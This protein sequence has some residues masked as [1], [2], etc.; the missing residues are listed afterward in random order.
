L[1]SWCGPCLRELPQLQNIY[2]HL[3]D[4]GVVVLGIDDEKKAKAESFL[5]KHHYTFTMLHDA[6]KL[7]FKKY[8]ASVIPLTVIINRKGVISSVL[9]GYHSRKKL[10]EAIKSAGL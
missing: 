3:K 9:A 2:Q 6:G 10:L 5:Q 7:V 4:H 8:H 1:A